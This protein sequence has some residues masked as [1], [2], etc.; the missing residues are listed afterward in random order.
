MLR[1]FWTSFFL[2]NLTRLKVP[3]VEETP[4][5]VIKENAREDIQSEFEEQIHSLF[6]C[7]AC[8]NAKE[9]NG[10]THLSTVYLEK[11]CKRSGTEKRVLYN[12]P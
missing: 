8:D 2:F 9:R 5:Y 6:L 12:G 10:Q 4:I 7:H 3:L 11:Q 1:D